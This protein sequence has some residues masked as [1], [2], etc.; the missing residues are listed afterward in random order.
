MPILD[1]GEI[2]PQ[3]PGALFDVTLGHAFLQPV[4]PDCGANVHAGKSSETLSS[5]RECLNSNQSWNFV[6]AQFFHKFRFMLRLMHSI[7]MLNLK[8]LGRIGVASIIAM[9]SIKKERSMKQ[10]DEFLLAAKIRQAAASS[11]GS[12]PGGAP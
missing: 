1:P 6:Q 12:L 10:E 4:G 7:C 5:L 3:Q 2:A 8:N 9:A 11:R